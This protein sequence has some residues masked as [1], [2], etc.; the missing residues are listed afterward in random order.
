M[1]AADSLR[2]QPS[3]LNQTIFFNRLAGILG[4]GGRESTHR[5][6]V[7]SRLLIESNDPQA[8][9]RGQIRLA[10]ANILPAEPVL[11]KPPP[12]GDSRFRRPRSGPRRPGPIP[13]AIVRDEAD[14]SLSVGVECGCAAPPHRPCVRYRS[15]TAVDAGT[16]VDATRTKQI[17]AQNSTSRREVLVETR[18]CAAKSRVG[19]TLLISR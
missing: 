4:A 17:R 19:Q 16:G 10:H 14:R 9:S 1:T 6:P 15:R 11:E 12:I 13:D 5:R 2:G 3:P 7:G 18:G 8:H